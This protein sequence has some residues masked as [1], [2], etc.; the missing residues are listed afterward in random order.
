[1]ISDTNNY[2]E[3]V[4]EIYQISTGFGLYDFVKFKGTYTAP[5]DLFVFEED[6]S[7]HIVSYFS[8]K[9]CIRWQGLGNQELH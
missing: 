5:D 2:S 1:V 9:G 7:N 3:D 6:N 4:L 8:N